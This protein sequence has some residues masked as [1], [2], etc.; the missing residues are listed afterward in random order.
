MRSTKSVTSSS[1]KALSSES[2]GTAWRTLAKPRGGAAPTLRE[3]LVQRTQVG[4]TRLDR[5][6]ALAQRVI[7]GVR[8]VGA[9]SW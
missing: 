6:V 2:I 7:L 4:K 8:H 5:V 1:E 3:R 9:S